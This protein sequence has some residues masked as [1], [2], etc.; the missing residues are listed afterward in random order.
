MKKME[1]PPG[2]DEKERQRLKQQREQHQKQREEEQKRNKEF[3]ETLQAR[4]TAFKENV[5]QNRL[6]LE[7]MHKAQ[8]AIVHDMAETAGLVASSF[9][10][11][12]VDRH[13]ILFK[14][15]TAP[16]T[17]EL[18]AMK[19]GVSYDP[20]QAKD[21]ADDEAEEARTA[22]TSKKRN[23]QSTKSDYL[24]KYEKHLGGLDVAK[25]AARSTETNRS[26]GFVSSESKKDKRTIEETLA[27]I[28]AKKKQRTEQEKQD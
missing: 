12:E 26:Y 10:Q 23:H 18:S 9:G 27:D 5:E 25:A 11:E 8:R 7:P 24:Q 17:D 2:L 1:K 20:K 28:R 14:P 19:R 13:V 6:V 22:K 3:R 21:N 16:S 15:D 4:V